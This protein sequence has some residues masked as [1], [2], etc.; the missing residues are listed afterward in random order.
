MDLSSTAGRGRR[1]FVVAGSLGDQGGAVARHLVAAGHP[2]RALSTAPDGA[3]ARELHAVGVDVIDADLSDRRSVG[4]ACR[5]AWG[6]FAAFTPFDRGGREA[7]LDQL[8]VLAGAAGA[9]GATR[10]VTSSVGDTDR[11]AA[12]AAGE[13]WESERLVR[14]LLP[15]DSR[16][17]VSFLRPAY[18]MEN[19]DVMTITRSGTNSLQIETPLSPDQPLQWI[20]VADVAAFAEIALARP[21]VFAELPVELAGDELT[22]WDAAVM[23]A[24]NTGDIVGYSRINMATMARRSGHLHGMYRWFEA[25][26]LYAA[27][28]PAL[29]AVLPGLHTLEGWLVAGGLRMPPRTGEVRKA[30]A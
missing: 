20:A 14:D 21:S 30:A 29:R 5:G 28:I 27:D 17:V 9:S 3:T 24:R 4:D 13:L 12:L 19:L 18:F 26:P 11:D 8:A 1:L 23:I 6:V 15:R 10:F 25:H 22:L 7:E 2:V 16:T